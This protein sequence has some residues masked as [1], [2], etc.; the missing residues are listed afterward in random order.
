MQNGEIILIDPGMHDF[1]KTSK[2]K[3]LFKKVH[4]NSIATLI[5]LIERIEP[6]YDTSNLPYNGTALEKKFAEKS[7]SILIPMFER[8]IEK[9]ER[10]EART[11]PL[12]L[13][14]K[15]SNG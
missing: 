2:C 10:G 6:D 8:Y 3:T 1:S 4:N 13:G 5:E 11:S 14:K 7:L 15:A 9:I 12:K